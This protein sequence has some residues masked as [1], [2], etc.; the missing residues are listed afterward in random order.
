VC[1]AREMSSQRGA[2]E[3]EGRCSGGGQ[4]REVARQGRRLEEPPGSAS[5]GMPQ[6]HGAESTGMLQAQQSTGTP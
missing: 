3:E 5:T 6:V 4:R 1:R 2:V